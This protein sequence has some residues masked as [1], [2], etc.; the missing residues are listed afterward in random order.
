[1]KTIDIGKSGLNASALGIGCMRIS[2]LSVKETE[3]LIDTALGVGINLFDHADLYSGGICEE[4]FGKVL[5]QKPSLREQMILQSKCGIR[6]GYY[7]L[8]KDYILTSVDEILDRLKTDYLDL[9]LLHRPDTLM[10][11]EEI[12]EAFDRLWHSGKVRAFG[13][14]NMN[15]AQIELLQA[16]TGH[17]LLV[18]QMQF[19]LACSGMVDSGIHANVPTSRDSR[20]SSVLEYCRLKHITIQTWSPLQYGFFE[21]VFLGSDKYPDLNA[22]LNSLAEK[23]GVEPA[24]VAIAWILRHPA[25]MQVL[26]G[27]KSCRRIVQMA[28]AAQVD[29]TREEWYG[30]YCA[31]GNVLP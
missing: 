20:D 3:E 9:F 8:S 13:V 28:A 29:L 6:Q 16:A 27:S 23:Y 1:M 2:E 22:K 17:R 18:N 21:G 7:D 10:E 19:S 12:A 25:G 15:P 24:A 30:L 14:S 31:A 26:T 5:A 11:P 4:L